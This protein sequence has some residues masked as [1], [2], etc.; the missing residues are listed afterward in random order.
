MKTLKEDIEQGW[1]YPVSLLGESIF[2]VVYNKEHSVISTWN[3][4][5][6]IICTRV[7]STITRW[8]EFV[9]NNIKEFRVY[10]LKGGEIDLEKAY[11]IYNSDPEYWTIDYENKFRR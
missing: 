1:V 6:A 3:A 8:K 7:T 10:N 2:I 5:D 4:Y 9:I 11:N